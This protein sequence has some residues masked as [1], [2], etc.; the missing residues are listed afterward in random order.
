MRRVLDGTGV[1][2]DT[3]RERIRDRARE[4]SQDVHA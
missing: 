4:M 1:D 3:E 2:G